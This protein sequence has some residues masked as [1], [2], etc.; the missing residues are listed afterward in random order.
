[1][2]CGKPPQGTLINHCG[3]DMVSKYSSVLKAQRSKSEIFWSFFCFIFVVVVFSENNL[4]FYSRAN[5]YNLQNLDCSCYHRIFFSIPIYI[6]Y[7][8]QFA[9]TWQEQG[10][11]KFCSIPHFIYKDLALHHPTEYFYAITNRTWRVGGSKHFGC[12]W[13]TNR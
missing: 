13:Y 3:W 5:Q 2:G 6:E 7:H 1:M 11:V 4:M 9:F 10:W 12:L 8:K